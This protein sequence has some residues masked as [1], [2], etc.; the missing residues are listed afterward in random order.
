M[1]TWPRQ[2]EVFFAHR[3]TPMFRPPELA[4]PDLVRLPIGTAADVFMLGLCLY[5]VGQK[6]KKSQGELMLIDV[7][8]LGWPGKKNPN[9]A[10]SKH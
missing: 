3:S 2:V 10:A 4:D 7:D 8:L 6:W 9:M 5:Q 1:S